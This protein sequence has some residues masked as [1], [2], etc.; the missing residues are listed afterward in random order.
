MCLAPYRDTSPRDFSIMTLSSSKHKWVWKMGAKVD[1]TSEC[2][3]V[4][5]VRAKVIIDKSYGGRFF[6]EQ[7][8]RFGLDF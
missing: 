5:T 6:M 2:K 8:L 1:I 3:M 7:E 4:T